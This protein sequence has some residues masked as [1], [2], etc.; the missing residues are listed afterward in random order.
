ML[1][2]EDR[3]MNAERKPNASLRA[4]EPMRMRSA[5]TMPRLV[6]ASATSQRLP[7]VIGDMLRAHYR[8]IATE[9][10]PDNLRRLFERLVDIEGGGRALNPG[11]G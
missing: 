2:R 4:A 6:E 1:G 9:P 7:D 10:L 8:E 11:S 5:H 3:T